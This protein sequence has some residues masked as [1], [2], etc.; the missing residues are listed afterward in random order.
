MRVFGKLVRPPPTNTAKWSG[1]ELQVDFWE[2]IG[3]SPSELENLLQV[4]TLRC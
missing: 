3:N 2:L 4:Q 1:L